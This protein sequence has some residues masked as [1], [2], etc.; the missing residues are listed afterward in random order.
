MN[1]LGIDRIVIMVKDIEKA[2]DL[3][4]NK[5]GLEIKKI[6][7]DISNKYG[8]NMFLCPQ[9][10]LEVISP[11]FPLPEHVSP[12]IKEAVKMLEKQESV[13]MAFG[14]KVKNA[15]QAAKEVEEKG[16]RIRNNFETTDFVSL[17]IENLIEYIPEPEDTLGISIAFVQD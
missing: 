17:G 12:D 14:L 9:C 16:V 4:G 15:A 11:I 13:I 6:S 2:I 5:Y 8:A 10:N 7:P 1:I 3:F